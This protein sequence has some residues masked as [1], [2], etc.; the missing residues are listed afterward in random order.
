MSLSDTVTI[1]RRANDVSCSATPPPAT[2]AA[3]QTASTSTSTR[4]VATSAAARLGLPIAAALPAKPAFASPNKISSPLPSTSTAAPTILR[5][6][7]VGLPKKPS[8]NAFGKA[9]SKGSGRATAAGM[10]GEEEEE[11]KTLYKPEQGGE[12]EGGLEPDKPTAEQLEEIKRQN[13]LLAAGHAKEE[14]EDESMEVDGRVTVK[15]E[16]DELA[17][18]GPTVKAAPM[19]HAQREADREEREAAEIESRMKTDGDDDEEVDPLDAYMMDVSSEVKKVDKE[20]K[21]NLGVNGKTADKKGKNTGL[22]DAFADESDDE[23]EGPD[24]DELDKAGLR[25]ED[26]LALAAKKLKKRDLQSVNHSKMNYEPFR[27]AF[28]HPPPEI[29]EMTTE[30]AEAL[31]VELDNIKIRGVDCPK[32]ITKWSHCGLPA[33]CLEVI[34][35]LGYPKPTS[36][37]SQAIP[38]IMSGRD[39][40]GVAKTGSGKT[41]AFLLPMFR[42]IKDQR[43]LEAMEGPIAMIMT[44]TRELANQIA[45]EAKPFLKALGLRVTCAYG[46]SPLKDNIADLKRGAEVIVCTPGRMIELLITNSGRII[47]LR[48]ITYLVLDE[49]DRMFDMGFEP[50]VMKILGQIRPDRQTVLFS[51]TFPRA[52]EALARKVLRKPLEITVGG[53]SVVAPEIEQIM[54]VREQ[55]TK[56]NRLLEI[57]GRTYNDDPEAR[58]LIFVHKQEDADNLLTQLLSK[59]YACMSLHGGKD[60][61]DR[62]QTISDFKAGVIPIVIATSV[63]ARGLDVKQLKLVINYDCPNHMEDYVH[64]AGRTGRAGNKGTCITFITP[65]Q[66]RYAG[67]LIKALEASGVEVPEDL[68]KLHESF[69]EKVK[70]GKAKI[71][72]SGFGG[73]GLERLEQDR[74]AKDRAQRTAYGEEDTAK[75]KEDKEKETGE[76]KIASGEAGAAAA[77]GETKSSTGQSAA[78]LGLP[79]IDVEVRR[80]PAPDTGKKGFGIKMNEANLAALKAAEEE[81][82]KRGIKVAGLAGAQ[83]VIAKLTASIQAKKQ[84]QFGRPGETEDMEAARRRDPDATDFHAIV[85]ICDYPQKARWKVTNKETMQ[86]LI[87]TTGASITNKGSY[88]EKG[89]EPGPDDPPKLHLLIE[90]NDEMRVR[91]AISEIKRLLLD[92]SLAAME[93]ENRPTQGRYNVV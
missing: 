85:P 14:E 84:Q 62:D 70:A 19:S 74:E 64:R 27:K 18:G 29:A 92:S 32:P 71:A 75:A 47:N 60:Q 40:I 81:A 52:M 2:P 41:V 5:S 21:Q 87:E 79:D 90:S 37:Q 53:R 86:Q 68:K 82:K 55:S 69:I 3:P 11:T 73:K 4:P 80:G 39:V 25:P 65:D 43:P 10:M 51:A 83:S 88:Y 23:Y 35:S 44:P 22:I 56:F 49:A 57:L 30:E 31:R 76:K 26:I 78:D 61:V 15:D 8:F 59:N 17:D 24:P 54:E 93:Q 20:D 77:S 33:V 66:D 12:I 34:R 89:K 45:R 13:E 72:G 38:A 6:A 46:G 42:H 1:V 16:D 9:T 91:L 63:A 67:D 7:P 50:Q 28:Y 58:T 36:I 48:R